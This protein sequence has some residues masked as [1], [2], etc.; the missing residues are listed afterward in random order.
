MTNG[1]RAADPLARIRRYLLAL[2]TFGTVATTADLLLLAHYEDTKQLIPLTL[3]GLALL[4]IAW[5][6]VGGTGNSI[7][8][9]Q[10]VMT[11]FVLA[12]MVGVVLHYQGNLEFQLDIDPSQSHWTLFS[13]VMRA[14]AP[15][16]LAPGAMAQLGLLGLIYAYRHPALDQSSP[17]TTVDKGA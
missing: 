3:N 11:A 7:R 4:A 5:Y 8:L 2:V 15:P 17:S 6:L 14:K 12:G 10:L 1:A 13:K 16:A 9:L